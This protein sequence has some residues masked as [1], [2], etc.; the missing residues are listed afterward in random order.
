MN[1]GS[2]NTFS[3]VLMYR[4]IH[5][6]T[7]CD[8]SPFQSFFGFGQSADIDIVL[9]GHDT[10]RTAEIKT[11]DGRK[12]RHYLYYDG[13]SVSGKVSITLLLSVAQR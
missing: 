7:R 2:N 13:E 6:F 10:R 1:I 3:Y 4:L 11:E 8:S 5:T 9:D 12:E